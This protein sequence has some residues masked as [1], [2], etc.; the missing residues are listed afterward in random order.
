MSNFTPWVQVTCQVACWMRTIRFFLVMHLFKSTYW[1][2]VGGG[3]NWVGWLLIQ[4]WLRFSSRRLFVING[5]EESESYCSREKSIGTRIWRDM[6]QS[7]REGGRERLG[8]LESS[9][10]SSSVRID[11]CGSFFPP[12]HSVSPHPLSPPPP[13]PPLFFSY[14]ER[15]NWLLINHDWMMTP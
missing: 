2:F 5:K 13:P 1:C 11:G 14:V 8:S 6:A 7:A 3:W 4:L 12:S 10:S 15:T 9:S